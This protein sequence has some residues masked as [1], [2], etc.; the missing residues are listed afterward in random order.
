M[1]HGVCFALDDYGTGYANTSAVIQYPFSTVKL[2]KSMLWS[3]FEDKKAMSALK[4]SIAMIK[5]MGMKIITEGVENEE[6]SK[7]LKSMGCDYFQG[8]YYSKAVSGA[9]FLKKIEPVV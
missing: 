7:L 2:D 9:E 8:Y 5:E 1:A 3:A 4:F 6:Q